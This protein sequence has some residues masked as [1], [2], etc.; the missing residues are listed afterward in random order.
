MMAAFSSLKLDDIT[1]RNLRV[2]LMK[3][4]I[5]GTFMF[6][7]PVYAD[8]IAAKDQQTAYEF[9][10][11]TL[12]EQQP[13][14]LKQYKGKV[15]LIVN[16]ASR[17]GFTSQYD[18]LE[19]LYQK[20]K[21][22]GLIVIGVPSNDFGGQ[23]PGTNEEIAHFC[24]FNYGVTFPM[25]SK[26]VVSGKEAHPFYLWAQKTL[27]FGTAPKWNFHKYLIN[28]HGKLVDYFNSTISPDS[29]GINRAIEKALADK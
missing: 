7:M 9:S 6:S 23:E 8:E 5:Y 26:E 17:C 20:H 19:K 10:F 16:T 24:K 27:G 21:E 14:A 3:A 29:T 18:G 15:L 25:A 13:L 4:F 28:R 22:S 2:G 11:K 1:F 12:T